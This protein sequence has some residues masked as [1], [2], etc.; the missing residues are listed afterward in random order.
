VLIGRAAEV[1]AV[2]AAIDDTG[3]LVRGHAGIGK[4]ALLSDALADV[5][6]VVTVQCFRSMARS[7]GAALRR[8]WTQPVPDGDAAWVARWMARS[9]N[10]SRAVLRIEDLQWADPFLRNVLMAL[11]PATTVAAT[12]RDGDPGSPLAAAVATA[13]NLSVLAVGPLDDDA[14]V[15]LVRHHHPQLRAAEAREVARKCGGNPLLMSQLGS[16]DASDL[17]LRRTFVARL[18]SL[19]PEA[20]QGFT[21]IAF[22]EMPLPRSWVRGAAVLE[23]A[24]AAV[25][26][27]APAGAREVVAQAEA[28]RLT[29]PHRLLAEAVVAEVESRDDQAGRRVFAELAEHALDGGHVGLAAQWAARAGEPA[30][31]AT[32]AEQ[33][34]RASERLGE[35]A[36]LF[37]LAASCSEG[38]ARE[39]LSTEAVELLVSAGEYDRAAELID[40]APSVLSS[41]LSPRWAGLVGRVR[42]QQGDSE[43]ARDW[44]ER[45]LAAAQP[46]SSDEVLLKAELARVITLAHGDAE[47]GVRLA[48]EAVAASDVAGAEQAR[49]LAVLGTAEN[50]AGLPDDDEHLRRAVE[51]AS[52][53]A[54]VMVEFTS[55]NNLIAVLESSGSGAVA[56]DLARSFARRAEDLHLRSWYQQMVA[57][58]LNAR[59]HLGDYDAVVVQAPD[60]LA[61]GLDRR[62]RDQ[63]EATLGLAAGDLGRSGAIA[64]VSRALEESPTEDW[65]RGNLLYVLAECQLWS[66]AAADAMETATAAVKALP[67]GGI[68]LFPLLSQAHAQRELGHEV[69]AGPWP[70]PYAPIIRAAP[71]ELAGLA[72]ST[73]GDRRGA[74]AAFRSATELWSGHHLRGELRCRWLAAD[75]DSDNDRA[76]AELVPLAERLAAL[77]WQPLLERVRRSL[78]ERGVRSSAPRGRAGEL[79]AREREI[80]E[81][82]A[83]G[84]ATEAIAARLK[85]APATVTALIVSARNRLGAASRWQAASGA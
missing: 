28:D 70:E 62:T 20:W 83:E 31:A 6:A 45:G 79:T 22:A 75:Q 17:G 47:V 50:F 32:L 77:G 57:M 34:G 18:R 64:R 66:G 63:L 38:V 49:A 53:S 82:V 67:E 4:T 54:D 14:G 11:P 73:R 65:T 36:D 15:A 37:A 81:L 29:A 19:G 56:A 76:V 23:D 2:R 58:E 84:L 72:A 8:A 44:Y 46:G 30:R 21:A 60:L 74:V 51:L 5:G 25:R 61:E 12:L 1:V 48:R 13:L 33:A 78:R 9:L 42:W 43:A 85:L 41:P 69:A 3:V 71:V 40:L 80:L 26:V 52:A 35:R 39:R 27:P 68:Q 16:R 24:G 10:H 7:P 55:A 59:M